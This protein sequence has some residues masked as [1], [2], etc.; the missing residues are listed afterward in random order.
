MNGVLGVLQVLKGTELSTSQQDYL[1][2]ADTAARSLLRILNDV[3][4]FSKVEAGKM[5]LDPEPF[6]LADVA[7]ELEAILLASRGSKPIALRVDLDPTL[8]EVVIGDAG[9]LKQVLLNLGSNAIKFTAQGE[10]TVRVLVRGRDQHTVSLG[11]EVVDTGIGL[12]PE[13][14]RR[15]FEGFSQAETSTS[16]RFGGTGLGLTISQRMVELLGGTLQV[17]SELGVGSTFSFD[18]TLPIGTAQPPAASETPT[19][20]R[21][22]EGVRILVVEDNPINQ[23][24][25][26]TLL[27]REG[28]VI[29]LAENGQLALDALQASPDGFDAVLMDVQMPVMDGL[30]ATRLIRQ[31]LKLTQLPILAMTA[32]AMESDREACLESG[33][34]DH[35]G[36]PF[37]I[38]NLLAMLIRHAIIKK[39]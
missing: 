38:Q 15:V 17:R 37:K 36:K 9:R 21:Q 14:Q 22:L 33:M 25:A 34:N 18:L 28:A 4:D 20:V 32:N 23:L 24:V 3:L 16:R 8:P 19:A 2:K 29:T 1:D 6:K 26:K 5:E 12:S 31:E 39:A 30:E 27:L 7:H 11:F 13:Q 10:V 35:I